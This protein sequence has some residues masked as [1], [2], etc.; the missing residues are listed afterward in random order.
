MRINNNLGA[1]T[2]STDRLVVLEE[3]GLVVPV[4]LGEGE[5]ALVVEEGLVGR[6]LEQLRVGSLVGHG[7]KVADQKKRHKQKHSQRQLP[8]SVISRT[9]RGKTKT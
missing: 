6:H 8:F 9:V 2:G 4:L 1:W 5:E 3:V 7:L